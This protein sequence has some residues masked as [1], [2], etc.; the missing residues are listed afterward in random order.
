V[1]RVIV[2]NVD[3]FTAGTVCKYVCQIVVIDKRAASHY[4]ACMSGR[5]REGD[6]RAGRRWDG[7]ALAAK[8]KDSG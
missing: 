7:T 2:H 4:D 5:A 1:G 3:F 6:G 8:H